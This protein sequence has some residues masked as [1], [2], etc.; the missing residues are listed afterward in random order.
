MDFMKNKTNKS[1]FTL[2][3]LLVVIAIIGLLSSVVLASLNT[4]RSKARD[5]KRK[6]DL[7]E[8]RSALQMY[9]SDNGS[10]PLQYGPG[11]GGV[12]TA[13]GCGTNGGTSG[14]NAYISGLTPTYIST[15]PTDP[16][17]S[18]SYSCQGYL[19]FS[20]GAN[21]KIIMHGVWEENYPA[22]GQPWYDPVRPTWAQMLC[23][24]EPACSSW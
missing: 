6:E 16:G 4:A 5:V 11:W 18:S 19:Y 10:Y 15:L 21:Y 17:T 23:S 13:V 7:V 3:E 9:Y 8:L 24:G 20:D 22:A 2:I 1:G 12:T 14:A